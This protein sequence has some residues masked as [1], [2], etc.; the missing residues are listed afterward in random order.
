MDA[1]RS[2]ARAQLADMDAL[3]VAQ[4]LALVLNGSLHIIR[5]L[6]KIGANGDQLI[7]LLRRAEQEERDLS[8][9][10]VE[11]ALA[12]SQ[13]AINVLREAQ[14]KAALD[15]RLSVNDDENVNG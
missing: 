10:E 8:A 5:L 3:Q 6:K 7:E 4:G 1:A 2:L 14:K 15:E 11:K 9:D 12:T 13:D